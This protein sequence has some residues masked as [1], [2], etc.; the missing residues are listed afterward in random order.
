MKKD[1]HSTRLEDK[2]LLQRTLINVNWFKT[3]LFA[4]LMFF[5][6][7][8]IMLRMG[9]MKIVKFSNGWFRMFTFT[10]SKNQSSNKLLQFL[11]GFARRLPT[12]T[13]IS[14]KYQNYLCFYK[15]SL[16]VQEISCIG[17]K[18][19]KSPESEHGTFPIQ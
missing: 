1:V 6:P 18:L 8:L 15:V 7:L 11:F 4:C 13:T 17:S 3:S 12:L 2:R 10:P 9:L 14:L 19:R 5:L 16:K